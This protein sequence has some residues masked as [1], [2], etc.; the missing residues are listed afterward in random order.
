MSDFESLKNKLNGIREEIRKEIRKGIREHCGK[1][2]EDECCY[3]LSYHDIENIQIEEMNVNEV[4]YEETDLFQYAIYYSLEMIDSNDYKEIQNPYKSVRQS[5]EVLIQSEKSNELAKDIRSSSSCYSDNCINS[6]SLKLESDEKDQIESRNKSEVD[7]YMG[8]YLDLMRNLTMKVD[9][10]KNCI[11]DQ[12]LVSLLEKHSHNY[13][14]IV[15]EINEKYD[16]AL[17]L[18]KKIKSM[19]NLLFVIFIFVFILLLV[20]LAMQISS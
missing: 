17:M 5:K 14:V 13:S 20:L 12:N 18:N 4:S 19:L 6:S 10:L 9:K 1:Q 15:N 3:L 16:E 8:I 2:L 11:G 7:S